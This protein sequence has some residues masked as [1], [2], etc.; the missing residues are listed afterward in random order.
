MEIK[1]I[2]NNNFVNMT[3]TGI[4]T[5]DLKMNI[6]AKTFNKLR[7]LQSL[8][9]KESALKELCKKLNQITILELILYFSCKY[10]K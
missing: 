8:I 5:P 2:G 10:K 3:Q 4:E 1:S 7:D 6:N 9:K